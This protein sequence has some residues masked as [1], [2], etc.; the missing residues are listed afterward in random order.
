MAGEVL[1]MTVFRKFEH[2]CFVGSFVVTLPAC[3]KPQTV[4]GNYRAKC[5]ENNYT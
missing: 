5:S 1:R 2:W 4:G 3:T